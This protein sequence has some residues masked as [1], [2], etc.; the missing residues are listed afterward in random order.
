MRTRKTI[1]LLVAAA[2]LAACTANTQNNSN[3]ESLVAT[4]VAETQAAELQAGQPEDEGGGE[5]A[6]EIPEEAAC[7]ALQ[8]LFA[9][10]A[11][12]VQAVCAGAHHAGVVKAIGKIAEKLNP[13][14]FHHDRTPVGGENDGAVLQ[15]IEK[16]TG[17]A[18]LRAV[19]KE[20]INRLRPSGD[21]QYTNE[22]VLFNILDL[23]FLE[24]W[25]VKDICQRL[26]LSEADFY[27]K[28]RIAIAA[29]ADQLLLMEQEKVNESI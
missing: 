22:W 20:A 21:R 18:A 14:V 17:V 25:K 4:A 24:G 3:D 7:E 9:P 11:H 23:K 1:M 13:V 12:G 29:V 10:P 5:Q 19:L 15:A 27:R 28:Q 8:A 16:E 6:A 2:V 26:S